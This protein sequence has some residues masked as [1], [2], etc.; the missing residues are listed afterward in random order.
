MRPFMGSHLEGWTSIATAWC[1]RSL[2][3]DIWR[4]FDRRKCKGPLNGRLR[5]ANIAEADALSTTRTAVAGCQRPRERRGQLLRLGRS[6]RHVWAGKNV[7][8]ATGNGNDALLAL[9]PDSGSSLSF[10]CP[11]RW[12]FTPKGWTAGSTIRRLG[13][14][15][16]ALGDLR[17]ANSFS[18]RRGKR[19]DEQSLALPASTRPTR[20]QG[21]NGKAKCATSFEEKSGKP[22][23]HDP[24]PGK[25]QRRGMRLTGGAL[26]G[27]HAQKN[28]NYSLRRGPRW[29]FRRDCQAVTGRWPDTNSGSVTPGEERA[30]LLTKGKELFLSRCVRCH[31]GMETK[32][33]KTGVPLSER[34]L[35]SDAIA[36][37]VN[38]RL[39]DG[40]RRRATRSHALHFPA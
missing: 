26:E 38:G 13:G 20:P 8:I 18:R 1:G 7:P 39:R 16:G 2:E 36:Q 5:L 29:S 4:S 9:L 21:D 24:L 34:G 28:R 17:N 6:V 19:D 23:T 30:R 37:A 27:G 10:A 11:I 31:G 40:N 33:L 15:E 32:P 25:I 22:Q 3:A 14:R 12:D 35:S